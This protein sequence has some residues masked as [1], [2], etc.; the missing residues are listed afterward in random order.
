M[1]GIWPGTF[2]ETLGGR[3]S[4]LNFLHPVGCFRVLCLSPGC[5]LLEGR[6]SIWF[7]SIS[8]GPCTIARFQSMQLINACRWSSKT[9]LTG[10]QQWPPPL[11][12]AARLS[13]SGQGA[14]YPT[15]PCVLNGIWDWNYHS[16]AHPWRVTAARSALSS[17]LR[18]YLESWYESPAPGSPWHG[19]GQGPATALQVTGAHI[20][21]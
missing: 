5:E 8:P 18:H 6:G 2:Q 14:D 13:F 9:A 11:A 10:G 21:G 3:T 17:P 1:A 16:P 4:R 15:N 19:R 12:R 20:L 7:I